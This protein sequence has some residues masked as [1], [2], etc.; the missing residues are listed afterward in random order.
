MSSPE[1]DWLSVHPC[2]RNFYMQI[3]E[4]NKSPKFRRASFAMWIISSVFNS[5]E[6]FLKTKCIGHSINIH[7][8]CET[9][10][11]QTWPYVWCWHDQ[12]DEEG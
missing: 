7:S 10:D 6:Y 9:K 12:K 5:I 8:H 2:Q 3:R 1:L 11:L 4:L